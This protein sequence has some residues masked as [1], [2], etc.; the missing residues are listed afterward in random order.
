MKT[1]K[2]TSRGPRRESV[3][4][5]SSVNASS[6][7]IPR[8]YTNPLQSPRTGSLFSAFPYPTKISPET[9]ALF[10]ASHTKPGATVFDGFAGSGTTG[11]AC[12]LCAKPT[13]RMRKDAERLGLPVRWGARKAVLNEIGTLGSFVGNMLCNPPDPGIFQSEAERVLRKAQEIVSWMYEARDPDGNLGE[14]R[15]IIWSEFV[16]CPK[17]R[18]TVSYWDACVRRSPARINPKFVCPHCAHE[19][20]ITELRRLTETAD[21][22]LLG[23]RVKTRLRKPVWIYGKTGK[24]EW[25]RP[26]NASDNALIRQICDVPLPSGIPVTEVAWGDLYRS[27]YHQGITHVHHFYSRRNLHIF[28]TLWQLTESSPLKDALRFWLLSYNASHATIMTRVVAKQGERDLV[29]TSSQPGVLYVSSLPVEKNLLQGLKR[30]LK[31]IHD[32]FLQTWPLSGTVQVVQ[33][34]SLHTHLA[35]QSVDYV[36]TD[37]PFGGNIPYAEV[38]FINEAWLG[39][40]TNVAEEVTISPSQNK[41][42]NDYQQLME[43]AFREI[44][45]ILKPNGNVT[46]VFHSSSSNVWNALSRAYSEAGLSV[47]FASVLDKT[48]GSFKQVTA[49]GSVKG[50]PVLLLRP[51]RETRKS[52]PAEVLP[53]MHQLIERASA[54]CELVEQTPQRLYSRFVSHYLTIEQDVPLSANEFYDLVALNAQIPHAEFHPEP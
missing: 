36:F 28:A 33:Q 21:D 34:S 6:S 11:V 9:I 50:D 2:K 15:Y 18:K 23:T 24:R 53:I 51:R 35:D 38:N 46:V 37:P 22:A 3:R 14:I 47:E 30:K 43:G 41:T 1:Q 52:P 8:L 10:I 44:A 7:R 45:R 42:T 39:N 54:S 17:C 29:V 31:T 27:G 20:N 4:R 25:S 16:R 13:E 12:L 40:C 26:I 19:Q 32:A 5:Q 48:Q 49:P